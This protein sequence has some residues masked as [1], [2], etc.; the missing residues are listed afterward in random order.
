[1]NVR[2]TYTLLDSGNYRKLEQVGSYLIDRPAPQAAWRQRMS[3]D[4]WAQAQAFYERNRTG[5]GSWR[6]Q[7]N[8]PES[9]MIRIHGLSL[10]V[11]LTDFGHL[12]FFP[13]HARH[14]DWIRKKIV[15]YGKPVK[16]LNLFAY[17]GGATMAA[18]AAGAS[19]THLDASRGIVGWARENAAESG[20]GDK[21]IR[22]IVDDVMKFCRR[23]IKRGTRYE[24]VIL[25]PPSF[26]RGA[27][28]EVWKF[29]EEILGLLDMSRALLCPAPVF[30]I[31]S[32]HTPGF[33]PVAL[34]NLLEDMMTGLQ[35][36]LESAE[37]F[38]PETEGMRRL[39][40][41]IM[42]TWENTDG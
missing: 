41:G 25:D 31:L 8:F 33:S 9:W 32:A 22:W 27:K 6:F 29:E 26:G 34:S 36:R 35:G 39:P 40:S 38:V 4:V 42:A 30:V 10:R 7:T 5:S 28:G 17:T 2:N 13:E 11:K 37:M 15:S 1:M 24:A 23:E 12:G 18:A 14:W 21:P 20:L 19:V 3:P 16:V